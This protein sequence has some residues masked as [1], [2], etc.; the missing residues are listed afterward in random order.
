V[1]SDEAGMLS[2]ENPERRSAP[3]S[4]NKASSI[5]FSIGLCDL[6]TSKRNG[7]TKIQRAQEP[8]AS[9]DNTSCSHCKL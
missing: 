1:R 9:L 7:P 4:G 8:P 3:L 5:Q 6:P 2:A